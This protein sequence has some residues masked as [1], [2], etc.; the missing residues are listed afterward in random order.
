M[1]TLALTVLIVLAAAAPAS[2]AEFQVDSTAPGLG[3]CTVAGQCTLRQAIAEAKLTMGP[4]T[5]RVP[6]GTYDQTGPDLI[7][8]IGEQL[9]IVGTDPRTTVIREVSG[10]DGRV[11]LV[12]QNATLD[13][14]GVT[15]TGSRDASAVLLFGANITFRATNVLFTQNT[16]AN[17]AAIDGTGGTVTLT[18]STVAG[19]TATAKGGG[20]F[21]NGVGSQL[22][23]VNSTIA[24]NSAPDGAGVAI[25]QGAA[26]LRASTVVGNSGAPDVRGA[27]TA[28]ASIVGTCAGAIGSLGANATGDPACGLVGAGDRTAPLGLT[29]FGDHGGVTPTF[30]PSP[31]SPAVD[32]DPTCAAGG[33]DQRGVPRPQGAACD[34]GAVE[35]PAAAAPTPVPLEAAPVPPRLTDL[36]FRPSR[37]RVGSRAARITFRL[38]R[39]ATVR[40]TVQ[41]AKSGRRVGTRCAVPTRRTRTRARCTR[42]VNVRGSFTRRAR[43]GTTTIQFAGRLRGRRLTPGRY[44]LVARPAAGG[45][46]RRAAFTVVRAVRRR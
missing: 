3:D 15:V 22:T 26:T 12:E 39:A 4:D 28:H 41:K 17:G 31:G 10:G 8:S 32:I 20:V 16:A 2:A 19:N 46:P 5:I 45:S 21:L 37:W 40:F 7:V 34:A 1:R 30:L 43:A 44:R 14:S 33:L 36:R 24:G 27:A 18:N 42:F 29:T 23:T 35:L 38:D 25:D 6:P 13:L 11:F 9:D